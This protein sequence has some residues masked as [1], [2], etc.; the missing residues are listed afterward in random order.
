MSLMS[1][2]PL[3]KGR[4]P[5]FCPKTALSRNLFVI[6]LRGVVYYAFAQMLD[7]LGLKKNF[8]FPDQKLNNQT[9][10]FPYT[11]DLG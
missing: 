1:V 10:E 9:S 6:C 2:F 5:S 7:F 8:S 3:L 11:K 4:R